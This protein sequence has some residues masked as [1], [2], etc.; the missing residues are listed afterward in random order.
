MLKGSDPLSHCRTTL[1]QYIQS[2]REQTDF[3][4]TVGQWFASHENSAC[5]I[6]SRRQTLSDDNVKVCLVFFATVSDSLLEASE[7]TASGTGCLW[8]SS[9]LFLF[10]F[11]I[12][13][14]NHA[15]FKT[16]ERENVDQ[17]SMASFSAQLHNHARRDLIIIYFRKSF[18]CSFIGNWANYMRTEV[19]PQPGFFFPLTR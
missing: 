18:W 2:L 1:G 12:C 10:C 13:R 19:K 4:F 8:P 3:D 17:K 11:L 15:A 5:Y 14:Q 7:L 9:A 16:T 6:P